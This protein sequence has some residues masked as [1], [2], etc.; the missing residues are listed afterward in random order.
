[1]NIMN[2]YAW[3]GNCAEA[4]GKRITQTEAPIKFAIVEYGI[5]LAYTIYGIYSH[6]IGPRVSPKLPIYTNIKQIISNFGIM[7]SV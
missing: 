3:L 2:K 4:I 5:T 6:T 7:L 1:M